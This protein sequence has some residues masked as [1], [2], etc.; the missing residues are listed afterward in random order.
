MVLPPKR[1]SCRIRR[2]LIWSEYIDVATSVQTQRFCWSSCW[3]APVGKAEDAGTDLARPFELFGSERTA[4]ISVESAERIARVA[5]AFGQDDDIPCSASTGRLPE[6]ISRFQN[7]LP[8]L[9][10]LRHKGAART[11]RRRNGQNGPSHPFIK[12]IHCRL[13]RLQ[14]KRGGGSAASPCFLIRHS[15]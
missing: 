14:A 9:C 1:R 2:R 7:R 12:T 5:Q 8:C 13:K 15:V 6:P 4:R 11:E 10:R 3:V